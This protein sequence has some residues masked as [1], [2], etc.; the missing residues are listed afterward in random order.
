MT[1][2]TNKKIKN[3]N[4]IELIEKYGDL[5]QYVHYEYANK[6]AFILEIGINH[7]KNNHNDLPAN[8]KAWSMVLLKK[9]IEQKIEIVDIPK[10]I[11]EFS[12]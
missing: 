1:D 10:L 6:F 8:W 7:I 11:N 9:M 4:N 12:Y 2:L 3:L 5:I